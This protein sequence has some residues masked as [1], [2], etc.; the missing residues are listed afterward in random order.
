MG[1]HP[2]C[3]ELPTPFRS[4]VILRHVTDR[5][6][7]TDCHF[8]MPAPYG[9]RRHNNIQTSN[10]QAKFEIPCRVW[11]WRRTAQRYREPCTWTLRTTSPAQH[12]PRYKHS[13]QLGNGYHISAAQQYLSNFFIF[14]PWVRFY[15]IHK[16][17]VQ[18]VTKKLH[19]L[20]REP[21]T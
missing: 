8:I 17:R 2:A 1:F 10:R 21:E 12:D 4:R 13:A 9:G 14:V 20:L 18:V 5:Q 7:D 6:T 16:W 19:N 11:E 3:F 15:I